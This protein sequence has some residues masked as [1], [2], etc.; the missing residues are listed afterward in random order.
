MAKR[1][2]AV[3]VSL[4]GIYPLVLA[5]QIAAIAAAAA[6]S[7]QP[8][9]SR[10]PP[11]MDREKEIAL[12]LSA[13]PPSVAS[14]AAVYVLDESGYAKVREGQNGFTAIVQHSL[15]NSQEPRCMSA[16]GTRT[17]LPRVLKVAELRAEGKTPR[18]SSAL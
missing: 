5:I 16:E 7:T 12:A 13:C 3:A 2:R 10:Q 14:K 8:A 15:P 11:L 9:G 4:A 17:H 1:P 6:Q 18:K